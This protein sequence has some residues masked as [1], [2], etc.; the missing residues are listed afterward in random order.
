MNGSSST[1]MNNGSRPLIQGLPSPLEYM[2]YAIGE[3]PSII[4]RSVNSAVKEELPYLR[5]Y[6]GKQNSLYA[7]FDDELDIE[8]DE[9]S[10]SFV[11]SVQEPYADRVRAIEYGGPTSPA[12]P[13]LRKAAIKSSA[14]L[15]KSITK[16]IEKELGK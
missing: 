2:L 5:G 13:V 11:Y 8:Y 16:N 1:Y 6:A 14:R 9:G 15:E 12:R 10:R 3:A 7:A 4:A